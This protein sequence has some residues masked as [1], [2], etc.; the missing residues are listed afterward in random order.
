M[1]MR[2]MVLMKRMMKMRRRKMKM[3]RFVVYSEK[4]AL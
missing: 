2:M 3:M 1:M 4:L